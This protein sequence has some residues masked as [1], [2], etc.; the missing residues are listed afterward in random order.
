[1]VLIIS[2]LLFIKYYQNK[3]AFIMCGVIGELA[4]GP[5]A[6]RLKHERYSVGVRALGTVG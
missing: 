3:R 4:C 2:C 5:D 1:M 6:W